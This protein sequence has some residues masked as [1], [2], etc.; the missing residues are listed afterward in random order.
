MNIDG[1][2]TADEYHLDDIA[3]YYFNSGE[4]GQ[5]QNEQQEL[6]LHIGFFLPMVS[7]YRSTPPTSQSEVLHA[8]MLDVFFNQFEECG[9][10]INNTLA[11]GF[12]LYPG[13]EKIK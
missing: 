12:T 8:G 2:K 7:Q 3:H 4:Y 5:T 9:K 1:E 13:S 11:D 10:R 6:G